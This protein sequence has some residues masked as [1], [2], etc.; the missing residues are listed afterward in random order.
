MRCYDISARPLLCISVLECF[1]LSRLPLPSRA[2]NAAHGL[3][4]TADDLSYLKESLERAGGP[5]ILVHS[6]HCN[7]GKTKDGVAEGGLRLTEEV[8]GG[9]GQICPCTPFCRSRFCLFCSP[10]YRRCLVASIPP[11]R[12][13]GSQRRAKSGRKTYD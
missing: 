11:F 7:E 10:T 5:G 13:R 4:G 9:D 2:L 3:V 6:A 1:R 8:R 12:T